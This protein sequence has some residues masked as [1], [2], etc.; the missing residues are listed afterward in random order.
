MKLDKKQKF[1]LQII[2]I[3]MTVIFVNI[4]RLCIQAIFY[5]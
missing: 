2:I 5:L 3:I 1:W 4:M